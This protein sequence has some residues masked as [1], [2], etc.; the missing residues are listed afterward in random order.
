MSD[1][2]R[3]GI[4]FACHVL[5]YLLLG[6]INFL[7]SPLALHIHGDALLILFI[8]LYLN[9]M[10]GLI[11]VL[12]IG[13]IADAAH[14]VPHGTYVIGYLGIWLFFVWGNRRIR[15]QNPLQVR[16]LAAGAQF[17]WL[18]IL[19]VIMAL[20][21]GPLT[22]HWARIASDMIFSSAIAFLAAGY[23]CSL[24]RDIL[25]SLGWNLEAELPKI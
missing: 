15:R 23:W 6:E 3:I 11:C 8:G 4:I 7:L 17:I 5:L 1:N 9:R 22:L 25:Y 12:L 10:G 21:T 16:A 24:Q 19:T 20:Q 13:F 14:P 18:S 2:G